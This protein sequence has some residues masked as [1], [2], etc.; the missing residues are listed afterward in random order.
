MEEGEIEEETWISAR[1]GVESDSSGD[2]R[3]LG[4]TFQLYC[5]L[6]KVQPLEPEEA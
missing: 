5:R 2:I 3:E 4:S 6:K 1:I